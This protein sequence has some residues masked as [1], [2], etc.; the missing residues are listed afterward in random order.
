MR[1]SDWSADVCSSDLAPRPPGRWS[2]CL[3]CAILLLVLLLGLLIWKFPDF[4]AQAEAGSAYAA[5]VG[6]SCRYFEG[7]I[8]ACCQTDF[9]PSMELES[10][11]E[12]PATQTINC[13]VPLLA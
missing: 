6:C 5:R 9:G 12:D 4:K 13:S 8:L 3:P 11:S 10:D 1:I 2:G 7:C